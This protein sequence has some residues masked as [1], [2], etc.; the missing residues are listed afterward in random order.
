MLGGRELLHRFDKQANSETR[1]L[2][3][4]AIALDP[5]MYNGHISLAWRF[6]LDYLNQ[7]EETGPEALC[8]Q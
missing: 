1:A 3:L 5:G 7:W 6:V 2:L 4:K 8:Q